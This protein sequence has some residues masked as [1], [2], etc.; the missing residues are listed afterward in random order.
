M[1]VAVPRPTVDPVAWTPPPAVGL[2][3]PYAPN[4]RLADAE[5]WAIPGHGPED[6]VVGDDG[7]LHTGTD[8]GSVLAISHG[9]GRLRR[10]ATT[11]GRPLGIELLHD[12]RLLVC[13]ADRGLLAVGPRD[14]AVEVLVTEVDGLPLGITNN[15]TVLADG[16]IWFTDSTQGFPLDH[17]VADLLEHSGTGRLIRRDPD[18]RTTTVLDGLH[19]ANGVTA[20]PDESA[21]LVAETGMFRILRHHLTG[22]AAGTTDEFVR[23]PGFPDNLSTGPSGTIWCAVASPR[24][25]LAD[26]LAP[27]PSLRRAVWSVPLLVPKPARVAIVLGWDVDGLPVHNLQSSRQPFFFATGVREHDGAVYVGSLLG[28]QVLRLPL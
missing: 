4:D 26:A 21:V 12:G 27:L 7:T 16:T 2:A 15:A 14:G 3:G 17:Y 9:G 10:V 1:T 23:V 28:G 13:D 25:R 24:N 18:G 22:P 6:V 19:F 8:D 20:L 11:G 5:V